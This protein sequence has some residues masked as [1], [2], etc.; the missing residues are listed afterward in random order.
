MKRLAILLLLF[1]ACSK[2]PAAEKPAEKPAAPPPT[3]A[4]AKHIIESSS[5]FS[6]FEFTNSNFTLPMKKSLMLNEPTRNAAED[7]RKAAV[8]PATT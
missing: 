8:T 2:E 1:V 5:D 6:E 7:L 3:A 4:E